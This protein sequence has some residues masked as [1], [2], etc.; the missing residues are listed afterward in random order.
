V[1]PDLGPLGAMGRPV[2]AL[3]SVAVDPDIVPLGAPVWIETEDAA[4]MRRLMVA[5]D[6]GAAITGAQRADIFMG[7]GEAAGRI[8]GG[9]RAPGRM[10]VLLPT[11]IALR[12]AAGR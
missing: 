10:A 11:D 5:Q 7:T 6:T 4:P 8:A 1:P 3:R 12:L 2:T 9:M